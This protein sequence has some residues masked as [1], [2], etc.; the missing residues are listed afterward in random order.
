MS[1]ARTIAPKTF[2]LSAFAAQAPAKLQHRSSGGYDRRERM[3]PK[4]VFPEIVFIANR[5]AS[6]TVDDRIAKE[7]KRP[8]LVDVAARAG[9]SHITVSRVIHGHP[10]VKD[11][12]RERVRH[13]MDE[14]G[15]RPNF[16]AR[17][18]VT[19]KSQVIGVIC[20]NTALYGPS[21][22]LIGLER[23]AAA[24]GY[25][26]TM[27]ALESLDRQ[28]IES[29]VER[30]KRQAV[31]GVV[32]VSPH[33][34][35]SEAFGHLPRDVPTVAIWGYPGTTIPVVSSGEEQAATEATRHLLDLGHRTVWH[36]AGPSGRIGAEHRLRGWRHALQQANADVPEHLTGDWSARSGF[37][38][39]MMLA[40]IGGLSAIFVAN[41]QMALGVLSAIREAG[42]SV[43]EDI[44]V[45]GFDDIPDAEFFSPPLT[46]IRQH[47]TELGRQGMRRL[48]E[49]IQRDSS[50]SS[51]N[52][53]LP[54][55][56]IIRRSSAAPQA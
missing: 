8:G 45:V 27:I 14:L 16:A 7:A 2:W 23:A 9:V 12:T 4:T 5:T 17:T 48:L 31:A 32:L 36:L 11:A 55:E 37:E 52:I 44:S 50:P 41:D 33:A 20:Y 29:A 18:L 6:M 49:L 15:Y 47:F 34:A 19:G 13:A 22:A 25:F 56:L 39:G 46:T 30:L 40:R 3:R 53:Y 28:A 54:A 24:A 51:G 43:P 26:V 21:A 35:M 42:K 38:A 10:S 1:M